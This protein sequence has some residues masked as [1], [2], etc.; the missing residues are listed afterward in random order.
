MSEKHTTYISK[1]FYEQFH[2]PGSRPINQDGLIFMR[3]F[4]Q[5]VERISRNKNNIRVLDAGCGTGNTAISLASRYKT[6]EFLGLDNSAPSLMQA[7]NKTKR[8]SLDNLQ[9]RKWNLLRPIHST[10]KY[11]II[12]CLGVLHHTA[13]MEKV[14]I[15]LKNILTESGEIYLW[16]YGKHGRYNHSLNMRLLKMLVETKPKPENLIELATDFAIN[17][18][19][20]L[21]LNE[22]I[23]KT[24]TDEMQ[25]N[26]FRSPVWIADQ[27]L[28][29]N[30]VLIDINEL[31]QLTRK[32]GFKINQLLGMEKDIS[33]KFNSP[34]L[35]KR[36]NHLSKNKQLIA[37]DLLLKPERYF[38]VLQ[39][40]KTGRRKR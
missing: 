10:S 40:A 31:L 2:F 38:V 12:L 28:N 3:R 17:T 11:D 8:L 37:A 39:K 21:P 36:Y 4:V 27:F 6:I 26:T 14:L 13:N 35:S 30:E 5:S 29:P 22:L 18:Q 20:G 24:K 25:L 15:N 34:E 7:I 32:T 23:G 1:K 16:I 33:G 9:F 19:Q